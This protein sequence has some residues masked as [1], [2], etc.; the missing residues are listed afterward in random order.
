MVGCDIQSLNTDK[1]KL[2]QS[3][4]VV[5]TDMQNPQQQDLVL[6]KDYYVAKKALDKAV[7]EKDVA[8]IRKGLKGFSFQIKKD[9]VKEVKKLNDKT[10]VP[11]LADVLELNQGALSGGSEVEVQQKELDR[12][13]ISA[14][15]QLTGLKFDYTENL[16]QTYNMSEND[17]VQRIIKQARLWWKVNK[18]EFQKN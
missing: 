8:V 4:D 1:I 16:S 10:F 18:N 17:D 9:V 5:K 12:L 6:A 11:D 14:L 15:E 3:K 13:I 2:E 7:Q